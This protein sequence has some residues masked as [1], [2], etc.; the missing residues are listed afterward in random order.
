MIGRKDASGVR[1]H[2]ASTI[3]GSRF[4]GGATMRKSRFMPVAVLTVTVLGLAGCS[5]VQKADKAIKAG[6]SIERSVRGNRATIDSFTSNI[7]SSEGATFEA[8]YVTTGSSP[9]TIVYAV[10]PPK[11]LAFTETPTHSS[12]GSVGRVDIVAN[13][14]GEYICTPPS[15]SQSTWSCEKAN[16]LDASAESKLF[17]F[18]TPS[19]WVTFLQDFS[20]A[21]GFA[22]DKITKSTMSV[23]GFNMQCVDFR[24][25]GVKGTSTICTT[26]QGILGYVKVASDNTS[27]EIKSY[28]SSP[29]A[30]LFQLPAGAKVTAIPTSFPTSSP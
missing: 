24:A 3:A 28:S 15:G 14:S 5:T 6:H 29:S 2:Y 11:G 12:S 13:S 8:T 26:S 22:G 1:H 30:S 9:A 21:A 17:D 10:Q 19:H 4:D 18:Y 25:T 20:L 23:N 7:K 16:S 27:F